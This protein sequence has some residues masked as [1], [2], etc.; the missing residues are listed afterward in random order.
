MYWGEIILTKNRTLLLLIMS[1]LI[2]AMSSVSA[3]DV[4]DIS[5]NQEI[6]SD[7][8]SISEDIV[9]E[10]VD[11]SSADLES[12]DDADSVSES[13]SDDS[14][15]ES[16][17]MG[18]DPLSEDETTKDSTSIEASSSSVVYGNDYSVTLKDKNGNVLSGKN[19]IFTFNGNNYTRATDSN[20][21]ASIKINAA[22]GTY[23]ISVLFEGDELYENSSSSTKV[24]VSKAS[25]SISTAT[26]YAVKG[27]TYSVVLKDKDGNV[28]SKK[29]V[30]LTYN[31]KTYNKTTNSKGIVSIKI[32]GTVAKTYKLTYKFAGDEYYKASSG[33]VS[34]KVKMAT[35]LTGASTV[36][37]GNKYSV[38][39]KNA[40]IPKVLLA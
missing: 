17:E 8:D 10:S 39:L 28:L 7:Q 3:S 13:E 5:D 24:T 36:V 38:T 34:L 15:L 21:V 14:K 19:L 6:I 20:G 4:S 18:S 31:G 11:L 9:S 22:A 23:I 2:L 1:L 29:N 40:K 12:T 26:K 37:K 25:T 32:T 16:S 30:I 27:E 33:S 35:S